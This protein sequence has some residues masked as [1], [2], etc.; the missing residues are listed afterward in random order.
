MA[1][2][3]ALVHRTMSLDGFITGPDDEMGWVFE[4]SGPPD[5]E[6]IISQAGPS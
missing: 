2:G 6:E 1:P 4:G 5:A 3:I